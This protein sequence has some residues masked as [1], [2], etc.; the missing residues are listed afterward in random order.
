MRKTV[1]FTRQSANVFFHILTRCNL[2]CRHCYINPNQHGHTTLDIDTIDRWLAIFAGRHPSPNVIFLGGEPTLHPDLAIAVKRARKL[3][4]A[5]VTIDTNGYLFNDIL[6]RVT[7]EEV[8]FFS[9]SLDGPSPSINDPLRGE[10]SFK[11]CTQGI[12]AAKRRGFAVSLIYTVSRANIDH[13]QRMP[14]LLAELGVDRFF[15]QVIG[16][17]GQWIEDELRLETLSQVERDA[18]LEIVPKTAKAAARQGITVTFPTVFLE[19]DEPFECAGV[20]ADNYFIFP[21]GRVYRCPLCEDYPLHSLEI[22]G[23]RLVE[24]AG[25]NEADLFPL[26]IPEGCVMNRI[27]QPRNLSPAKDGKLL[28]KIACCMLKEEVTP[29]LQK[30]EASESGITEE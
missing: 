7:P 18:W 9:F 2:R 11:Q 29:R 13:L 30:P 27:I 15:I 23:G 20:V 25:I 12:A 28:Y 6:D 10:G 4:Y 1:A 19:P 21:N 3:G 14:S 5:S 16:V 26:L 8:D 22:R 17:R 24:T